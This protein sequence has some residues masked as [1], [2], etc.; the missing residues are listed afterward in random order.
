[1]QLG[2]ANTKKIIDALMN[3]AAW[4]SSIF[5][6]L[7]D[8]AGGFYDHVPPISVPAPDGVAPNL[9]STD[10]QGDFTVSGMRTPMIVVSPFAKPQYVSHTPMET[11]SILKLI[12]TRFNVPSLTNRD[13]AA[14][15]MTEFFDFTAPPRLTIPPLPDQPTSSPCQQTLE[16]DPNQP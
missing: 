9:K 2:S 4:K 5:V 13:A 8:E 3:S 10:L 16:T 15:D 7:Y 14:N 12:E 11:T 6:L 1:V